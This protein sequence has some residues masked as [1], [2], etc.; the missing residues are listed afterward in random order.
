[1]LLIDIAQGWINATKKDLSPELRLMVRER[2]AKCDVC[3]NKLEMNAKLGQVIGNITNHDPN[4]PYYCGA[5]GCPFVSLLS[6]P[7]GSCKIGKWG[8]HTQESYF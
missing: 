7:D 1:M 4:S 2:A 5:C 8:P 6:A 3:P